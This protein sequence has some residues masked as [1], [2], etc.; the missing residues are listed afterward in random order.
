MPRCQACDVPRSAGYE[1]YAAATRKTP[2]AADGCLPTA[3]Q[4]GSAVLNPYLPYPVRIDDIAIETEDKNL[5]TFKFMFLDP[6]GR[7][8]IFLQGRPVRGTV[9]DRQGGN[10]HRHRLLSDRKGLRHVHGQQGRAGVLLPPHHEGRGCHGDPRAH[11]QLVPVER[12]QG[13]NIVIIGGGFAFTTLRSSIIY[14][15]APGQSIRNS[16]TFT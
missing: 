8:E 5:K 12:M 7:T 6:E 9:D 16:R 3:C 1:Q 14:M 10:P 15:L 2:N 4:G 11:G 13:K